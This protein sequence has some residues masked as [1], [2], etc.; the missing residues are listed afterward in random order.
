VIPLGWVA[1]HRAQ[2][3]NSSFLSSTAIEKQPASLLKKIYERRLAEE[4]SKY[5]NIVHP[6]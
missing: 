3:Q 1:G 4:K 5:G 2:R 6:V